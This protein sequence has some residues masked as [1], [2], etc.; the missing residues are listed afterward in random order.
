MSSPTLVG[1]GVP[2][3]DAAAAESVASPG[4]G[5]RGAGQ[6]SEESSGSSGEERGEHGAALGLRRYKKHEV[7]QLLS[8]C[9]ALASALLSL[10]ASGSRKRDDVVK[11]VSPALP[12]V[13]AA[14]AIAARDAS[15]ASGSGWGL[16]VRERA[17]AVLANM[18]LHEETA[19]AAAHCGAAPAIAMEVISMVLGL[20]PGCSG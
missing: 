17:L 12:A 2:S 8:N 3:D 19:I 14:A 18:C 5:G 16:E 10:L 6:D 1:E 7:Q 15:D 9:L 4:S 20:G 13:A 11:A